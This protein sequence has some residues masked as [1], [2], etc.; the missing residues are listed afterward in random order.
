MWSWWDSPDTVSLLSSL[1][2]WAGALIAVVILVLGHRLATLQKRQNKIKDDTVEE[3]TKARQPGI[4]TPEQ[5]TKFVAFLS[6]S[7]KGK[8]RIAHMASNQEAFSFAIQIRDALKEAGFDVP[9]LMDSFQQFGPP[10]IGIELKVKS[11]IEQPPFAGALQK[12]FETIDINA[13]GAASSG[14][15]ADTVLI[16]VG[17]K[18]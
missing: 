14:F 5:R 17:A 15:D 9:D 18:P 10:L 1:A 16:E 3:L 2:R 13:A 4:I 8:V 7:P 12:A 6:K 11:E